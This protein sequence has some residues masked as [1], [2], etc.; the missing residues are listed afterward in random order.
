MKPNDTSV[1]VLLVLLSAAVMALVSHF[2][3]EA[4][5]FD[6]NRNQWMPVMDKAYDS[7]FATGHMP[8]YDFYLAKGMEIADQ[9]FYSLYNPIMLLS[10][11]L[12]R[13]VLLKSWGST[14]TIYTY[15]MFTLGN[16]TAYLLSRK[17]GLNKARSAV[18]VLMYMSCTAFVLFGYWY[19]IFNNYFVVPLILYTMLRFKDTQQRFFACGIILAFSLTLGNIQYT[20]YQYIMYCI[21]MLMMTIFSSRRRFWEMIANCVTGIVLSLPSLVLLMQS[22]SRSAVYAEES[23]KF[24]KSGLNFFRY[25][26]YSLYPSTLLSGKF[27][28]TA[29]PLGIGSYV[30]YIGG[31]GICIAGIFF[32]AVRNVL[33]KSK[34]ISSSIKNIQLQKWFHLNESGAFYISIGVAVWFFFSLSIGG[35]VG[36]ILAIVPVINKFRFAFKGCFVLIPLLIVPAVWL[37]K[38][39]QHK[40]LLRGLTV[41]CIVFSVVGVVNNYFC[42][43]YI[44]EEYSYQYEDKYENEVSALKQELADQ[45]IDTQHYRICTFTQ[46]SNRFQNSVV[47]KMTRNTPISAEVFSLAAYGQTESALSFEQSNAIYTEYEE[48]TYLNEQIYT[49]LSESLDITTFE[50]QMI[51]NSVKYIIIEDDEQEK[52][53][54]TD[55]FEKCDKLTIK[56]ISKWLK[57]F[58]VIEIDGIMPLCQNSRNHSVSVD[59]R[60]DYIQFRTDGTSEQYRLS[61]TYKDRLRADYVSDDGSITENLHLTDDENGYIIV[62]TNHLPKGKVTIT[63]YNVWIVISGIFSGI[64][65]LLF[66]AIIFVPFITNKKKHRTAK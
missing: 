47:K 20:V 34:N 36:K 55:I 51:C 49:N 6:D 16:I 18:I 50:D 5:L 17:M 56:S 14:I 41:I 7:F 2:S 66:A 32:L 57:P 10:Y 31:F 58:S 23:S 33:K 37:F 15:V 65:T 24:L 63:Y 25:L 26:L 64:S 22:S 44:E 48:I 42:Y 46:V 60:T 4:F 61:F 45:N 13:F 12:Y 30:Y 38:R 52:K 11:V 1:I 19:Y 27:G 29:T 21:I 54:M 3:A 59:C 53:M 9:G 28:M 35:V 62:E 40:I 8:N 43:H 39:V